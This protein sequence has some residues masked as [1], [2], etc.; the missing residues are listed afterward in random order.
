MGVFEAEA[1]S[2][3]LEELPENV[4]NALKERPDALR[5]VKSDQVALELVAKFGEAGVRVLETCPFDGIELLQKYERISHIKGADKVLKRLGDMRQ[6]TQ[7]ARGELLRVEELVSEGVEIKNMADAIK[8]QEAADI[9]LKGN[10]I[11][12]TKEFTGRNWEK[13]PKFLIDKDIREMIKQV[14]KR[15]EQYPGAVIRY[16]FYGPVPPEMSQA[17]QSEGVIVIFR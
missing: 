9:V 2:A 16:V 13:Y 15:K 11:E 12:D 4:R 14:N 10:I 3:I 1:A 17:L 8:G 7:G 6:K 5:I